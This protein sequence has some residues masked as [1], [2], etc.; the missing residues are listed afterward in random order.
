MRSPLTRKLLI[1]ATAAVAVLVPAGVAAA[2]CPAPRA[3]CTPAFTGSVSAH[4]SK[5]L[6][7]TPTCAR[8]GPRGRRGA[9]GLRGVTGR[10]GAAGATGST[11]ARGA[12]GLRGVTGETGTRGAAGAAGATGP[13]GA[14][15]VTGPAGVNGATGATGPTGT[16]GQ[17]GDTGP[18]GPTGADGPTGPPGPGSAPE[19]AYIYNQTAQTVPIEADVIFDSNGPAT[20][21]F[22]HAPGTSQILVNT[23][24]DYRIGF[25]VT[26]VEVSQFGV[27]LNSAPAPETVYG[28]GSATEQNTGQAIIAVAAG[29]TLTLRNHSSTAAVNLQ[30]LAGGGQA[31]VNASLVIERVD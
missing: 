30:T 21:G 26:G 27:F 10:A 17:V 9:S 2:A 12:Q 13:I 1:S 16:A 29:D 22:T 15:G 31:N 23:A 6:V 7:R 18:T 3:P 11:G 4:S 14:T 25:S 5:C 24:G 20:A 19:Y 28:T 8:R